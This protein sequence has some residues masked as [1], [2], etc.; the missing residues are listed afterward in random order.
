[1]RPCIFADAHLNTLSR[2]DKKYETRIFY[3]FFILLKRFCAVEE[4]K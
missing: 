3:N 4:N 2:L 1:M